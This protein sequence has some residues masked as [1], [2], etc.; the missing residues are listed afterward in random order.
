MKG[1]AAFVLLTGCVIG[2]AL[3]P[4]TS[5]PNV[6]AGGDDGGDQIPTNGLVLDWR[7]ATTLTPAPLGFPHGDGTFD[8]NPLAAPGFVEDDAGRALLKYIAICALPKDQALVVDGQPLHGFYGLAPQWTTSTCDT[9]CQHWVM[10][11]VL[12]HA[13]SLGNPVHISLRGDHPSLQPAPDVAAAYTLQEAGFYGEFGLDVHLQRKIYACMGATASSDADQRVVEGRVCGLG[14]CGLLMAGACGVSG[15]GGGGL[16]ACSTDSGATGG[17]ADCREGL[18]QDAP[19]IHEV[20]TVY[21]A[22]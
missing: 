1:W 16:T 11:C 5:G 22:P 7:L 15:P 3:P 4:S 14:S 20:I 17:Y 18:A 9:S 21:T 6:G 13:N 12:A 8:V 19:V 10:G 2:D